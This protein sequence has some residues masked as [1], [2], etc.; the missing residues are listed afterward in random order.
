VSEPRKQL[1][2]NQNE[3]IRLEGVSLASG[4]A[5]GR[6]HMVRRSLPDVTDELVTDAEAEVA[7]LEAAV[8]KGR[9]QLSKLKRKSTA[10]PPAAAEEAAILLDAHMAMLSG[11]RLIRGAVKRI[12]ERHEN[13]A[14]AVCQEI[15]SI[16]EHFA[17]LEDDYLASR[18]NDIREVGARLIRNLMEQSY[19]AFGNVPP[20]HLI[21]AEEVTPADAALIDPDRIGGFATVFGGAEG[22]TAI[23]ARSL[24]IPAVGGVPD[25]LDL[26]LTTETGCIIDGDQGIVI[27]NP[28]AE[29]LASYRAAIDELHSERASLERL[30][31]LPAVTRDG[32]PVRLEANMEPRRGV[33][34]AKRAGATG[35]GLLRTEFMYMNRTVAPDVDEQTEILSAM[36][37]G[38]EGA[39]VTVRTL[40]VSPE[41][42]ALSIGAS[43]VDANVSPLGLRG[44]RLARRYPQLLRDQFSACIRAAAHGPVRILLPMVTNADEMVWARGVLG[45]VIEA[46][47]R[48][49]PLT[50]QQARIPL[51]AMIEVPAAALTADALAEEADFFAIGTNDLT[52]YALALDRAEEQVASLYDPHHPA[53]LRLIQFAAEAGAR[54]RIDVSVCGELAGDPR[55]LPLLVGLGI[56]HFSMAPSRLPAI[57]R[58]VRTLSYTAAKALALE[59]MGQN[60]PT[61]IRDRLDEFLTNEEPAARTG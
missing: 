19:S 50:E 9:R 38:M 3:E 48:L 44:I 20:G 51:G 39:P 43:R 54:A 33:E 42:G 5:L 10:L 15:S 26:P 8:A 18:L 46:E 17:T 32:E 13:A 23:M 40:D 53:L 34:A 2:D 47:A 36:V 1:T 41:K 45:E 58:R 52:Q 61:Y 57:K 16:G 60:D 30:A 4:I 6:I 55:F 37:E 29:T 12:Q 59:I 27:V 56:R 21:F 22:H 24:G 28:G 14:M 11:S 35:I 49:S 31:S 7:R 25:L